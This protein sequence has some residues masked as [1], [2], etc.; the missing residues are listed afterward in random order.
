M[1]LRVQNFNIAISNDICSSNFLFT[2]TFDT[3][4]LFPFTFHFKAQSLNVQDD[5]SNILTNTRNGSKLMQNTVNLD[6][7]YCST[8]QGGQQHTTQAV[9]QCN[10]VA[11]LER[12]PNEFAITTIFADI[13]CNHLR[14]SISIIRKASFYRVLP[15]YVS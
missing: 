14:F 7:G 12:L 11:S 6:V 5:I 13:R 1:Q 15:Q 9:A 10:A 8:R 4:N 3:Q 2:G